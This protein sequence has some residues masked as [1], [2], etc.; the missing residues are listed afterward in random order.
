[1][2][3]GTRFAKFLTSLMAYAGSKPEKP[4]V[5]PEPN[6]PTKTKSTHRGGRR[7]RVRL[8]RRAMQKASRKRNRRAA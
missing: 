2:R 3:L 4:W 6:A 8:R 1:M 7:A 5:E